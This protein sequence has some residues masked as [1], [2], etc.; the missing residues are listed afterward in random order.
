MIKAYAIAAVLTTTA[1]VETS[2][3]EEIKA[4]VEPTTAQSSK[5]IIPAPYEPSLRKRWGGNYGPK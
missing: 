4:P 5:I 2:N 3:K 1:P